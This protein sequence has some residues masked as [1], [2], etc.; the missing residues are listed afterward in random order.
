MKAQPIKI[1]CNALKNA[2][3]IEIIAYCRAF[4][5]NSS[6]YILSDGGHGG[7]VKINY[8]PFCGKNIII[9]RQ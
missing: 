5:P 9:E 1:C 8:C 7:M 2:I 3:D 6:P 4:T